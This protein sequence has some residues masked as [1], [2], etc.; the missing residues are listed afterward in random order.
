MRRRVDQLAVRHEGGRLRQPGR[1][2]EGRDLALRLVTRA[3]AAV[4][5]VEGGRLKKQRAHY[6]MI[7]LSFC[8]FAGPTAAILPSRPTMKSLPRQLARG[9]QKQA[10][11]T[12]KERRPRI[13]V[14]A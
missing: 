14:R 11:K 7:S 4:E 1:V 6:L 2:P 13:K 12:A 9:L 8:Y 5:S 3:G 10:K